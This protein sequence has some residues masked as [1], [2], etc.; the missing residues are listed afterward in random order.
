MRGQMETA[1]QYSKM[2]RLATNHVLSLT[3]LGEIYL[4]EGNLAE[5][6]AAW[7]LLWG[8]IQTFGAQTNCWQ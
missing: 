1:K 8:L 5:A 6:K 4:A 7:K 3:T 2:R